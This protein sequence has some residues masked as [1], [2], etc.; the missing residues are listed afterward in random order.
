MNVIRGT[1]LAN[2]PQLVTELGGDPA[3]LLRGAGIRPADVGNYEAFLPYPA[4]VRAVEDAAAAMAPT[5]FGRQL[6]RR[7]GIEILG[8][9]GV[10]ARTA[11]TVADAIATFG[12][13]MAA[14]SPALAIEISPLA[15]PGRSFYE[16]RIVIDRL[17]PHPHVSELS[18]GVSLQVL[19]FLLGSD[20]TPLSVHL[21]HEPLA[22]QQDYT[23]FFGCRTVFAQP[24]SG[25][26]ICTA[27]L[28]RPL[29]QDLLAHQAVVQYLS[30]LTLHGSNMTE[31]VRSIVRHLLPTGV[32]SVE[33][34]ADQFQLHPKTL[35]R[36]L[37]AEGTTLGALIDQIRRAAAER[38]LRDTDITLRHLTR[39]L[40]YTEQSELSRSC[41]RWF[42]SGPAA[43][44]KAL[45]STQSREVG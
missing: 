31:S 33:V 23:Q 42:G 18:L 24:N 13:F 27:D 15:T 37:A 43:Y 14:Y 2:Y 1:S 4:V 45:R 12:T 20:Y 30:T 29:K 19:R 39:E 10:A 21:P 11:A 22:A 34:I 36:R 7:Q 6:A 44:R 9:V 40:G 3:E 38:Y 32:T 28:D 5:D 41:R 8:P 35:Q 25:F 17:P 16:F 26:T